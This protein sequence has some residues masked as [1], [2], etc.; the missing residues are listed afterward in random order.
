VLGHQL[1]Q[2][3]QQQGLVQCLQQH[4]VA[5]DVQ[6]QQQHVQHAAQQMACASHVSKGSLFTCQHQIAST[7]SYL[8]S[9][10]QHAFYCKCRCLESFLQG[11]LISHG[12]RLK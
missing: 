11:Y 8:H 12:N 3:E 9:C 7:E 6:T 10:H 1:Q 4:F 2:Q 5:Q